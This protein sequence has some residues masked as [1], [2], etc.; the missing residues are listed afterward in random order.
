MTLQTIVK[1]A[2]LAGAALMLSGQTNHNWNTGGRGDGGQ[3]APHRQS[4][5]R[6]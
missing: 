1:A 3:R 5:K 2:A 6:K 4:L